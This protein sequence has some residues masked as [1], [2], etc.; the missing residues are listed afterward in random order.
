[1]LLGHISVS[2]LSIELTLYS[3]PVLITFSP[4]HNMLKTFGRL[5]CSFSMGIE[6][7]Y[8]SASLYLIPC[9]TIHY[10]GGLVFL[11]EMRDHQEKS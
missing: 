6:V 9:A 7:M 8:L 2:G 3:F 4:P 1:V 11:V 10:D 5:S